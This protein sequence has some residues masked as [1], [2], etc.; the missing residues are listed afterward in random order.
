MY[1]FLNPIYYSDG[2]KSLLNR[3]SAIYIE[4]QNSQNIQVA[5]R[6]TQLTVNLF[7]VTFIQKLRI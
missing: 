2:K 7:G 4:N 6:K 1:G 3:A 5:N